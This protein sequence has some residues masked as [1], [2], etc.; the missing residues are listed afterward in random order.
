MIYYCPLCGNE[1]QSSVDS[2]LDCPTKIITSIKNLAFYESVSRNH[3]YQFMG[4]NLISS[5]RCFIKI[6]NEIISVFTSYLL[7]TTQISIYRSS[8][9]V[10][11]SKEIIP[12]SD[13]NSFIEKIRLYMLFS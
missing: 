3:Y 8:K 5:A 6:D 4:N 9:P 11:K 2:Y 1:L 7:N 10:F 12:F 13:E